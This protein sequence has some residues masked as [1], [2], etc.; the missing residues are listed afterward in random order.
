MWHPNV[1]LPS[2]E[3]LAFLNLICVSTYVARAEH[4]EQE[5]E[6]LYKLKQVK[7]VK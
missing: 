4:I 5:R 2:K 7:Y 3:D 1:G 6:E